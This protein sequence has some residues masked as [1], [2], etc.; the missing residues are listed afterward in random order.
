MQRLL[1]GC[2]V[3][4]GLLIGGFA[5]TPASAHYYYYGYHHHHHHHHHCWWKHHRRYCRY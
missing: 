4:L 2:A 1:I 5:P 3:G